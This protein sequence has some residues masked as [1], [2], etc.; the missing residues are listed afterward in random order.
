MVRKSV[1]LNL[2]ESLL[3]TVIIIKYTVKTIYKNRNFECCEIT[4][5]LNF[6]F[7]EMYGCTATNVGELENIPKQ[8]QFAAEVSHLTQ[9]I[10]LKN[11]QL[12]S[13]K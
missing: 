7:A 8:C 11:N 5:K 4:S 12:L 6:V 13:L 3:F 10:K 1:S 2:P 9:V